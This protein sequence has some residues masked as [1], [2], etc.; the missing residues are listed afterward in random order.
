MREHVGS[1]IGVV[2]P[3]LCGQCHVNSR[4]TSSLEGSAAQT[5][6]FIIVIQVCLSCHM[7]N[8]GNSGGYGHHPD[9][10]ERAEWNIRMNTVLYCSSDGV[11][12]EAR[13][14]SKADI[15]QLVQSQ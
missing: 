11:V 5:Y 4:P 2:G 14:Y 7:G 3:Q 6:R 1:D 13:A 10:E 15:D 12:Y 8:S 9:N